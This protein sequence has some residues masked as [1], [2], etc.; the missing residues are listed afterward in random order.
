MKN[1]TTSASLEV[2]DARRDQVLQDSIDRG[3]RAVI[4]HRPTDRW[5]SHKAIFVCGSADSGQL[6]LHMPPTHDSSASACPKVG[7][8]VG[9]TFRLNHKKC[10][11][12]SLVLAL[13][14][15]EGDPLLTVRWPGALLQLQRRAYDRATPP[16]G[17]IVAV[18]LWRDDMS[19][20]NV[21]GKADVR[22]AQMVDLSAGGLSVTVADDDVFEL[23]ATY[24]C[25]F[26]TSP[27]APSILLEATLR[28]RTVDDRQR[29]CLGFQ[30]LGLETTVDGSR[31]LGR[32][33]DAVRTFKNMETRSRR[34]HG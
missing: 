33:A 4:A 7:D 34:R 1:P 21:S 25:V 27:G 12:H 3:V 28:H 24:R 15:Q 9:V 31:V 26:T 16:R 5:L 6:G 29:A 13:N 32:L 20:E 30:F 2:A 17:E 23:G 22:N 19:R 8:S 18:R 14:R 11:F 10:M